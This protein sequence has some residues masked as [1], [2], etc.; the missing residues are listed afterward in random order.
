M[1]SNA[2]P[3]EAGENV[4]LTLSFKVTSSAPTCALITALLKAV[5]ATNNQILLITAPLSTGPHA[6]HMVQTPNRPFC[7]FSF[8]PPLLPP[9]PQLS[10]PTSPSPPSS[11]PKPWRPTQ[12]SLLS[13]LLLLIDISIY[14]HPQFIIIKFN[15]PIEG[16]CREYIQTLELCT[17]SHFLRFVGR[18]ERFIT[19]DA[20]RYISIDPTD[21]NASCG[22]R[23]RKKMVKSCENEELGEN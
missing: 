20:F 18:R 23:G 21:F 13:Q 6:A 1:Y 4:F 14:Y 19:F 15:I 10:S 22:D 5:F 2:K 16:R 9:Q 7:L 11:S 12:P 8:C 17:Q 3:E